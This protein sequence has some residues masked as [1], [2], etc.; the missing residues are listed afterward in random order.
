MENRKVILF[1]LNEVP[2]RVFDQYCQD[3]PQSSFAQLLAQSQQ[4]E[5]WAEDNVHLSPTTTWPS[6]HRGV[7]F[8]KHGINSFGQNLQ[9]I[10]RLYPPLWQITTTHGVKTGVFAPMMSYQPPDD[11]THYDFYVPEAFAAEAFAHPQ[12]ISIFQQ[13]N[14]AMTQAS[15]SNVAQKIE[16]QPALKMLQQADTLGL[17]LPTFLDI[18]AQFIAERFQPHL[19][20]RRRSLQT[21]LGFDIFLQQLQQSQPSYASFFT[22]H[23]AAAMHRYWAATFP[24]DYASFHMSSE[25][26]QRYAHEITFAM[27][28]ADDLLHRLM[29]FVQN[30][31]GY[32]LLIAGSMGQAAL[33]AKPS[34]SFL[35]IAHPQKFMQT[36]GVADHEF[37]VR[38]SMITQF[39][40]AIAPPKL[41]RFRNNL[42][43]LTLNGEPLRFTDY[44]DGLF[45]FYLTY[46]DYQGSA[47]CQLGQTPI[48]F[49]DLGIVRTLH[50]DSAFLTAD[51]VPQGAL[52]VWD[53]KNP[54]HCKSRPQISALDLAPTILQNFNIPIPSYMRSPLTL[55]K[56]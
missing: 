13:F 19:R 37:E 23:V 6:L 12:C 4:Y 48:P 8:D 55:L 2:Y 22:N 11:L 49:E 3:K 56:S 5:T 32:V 14:I 24:D 53:A 7:A 52:L 30:H 26:S 21:L 20:T 45:C 51:H 31:S 46:Q 42:S 15:R 10:D 35:E 34:D 27:D 47:H 40:V 41:E 54:A 36:L 25:W 50:E 39:V 9:D 29:R 16:W 43:K 38:P 17:S 18:G 44:H 1:E 33:E 28:K